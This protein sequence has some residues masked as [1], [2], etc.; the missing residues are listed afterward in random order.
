MSTYYRQFMWL[1][2]NEVVKALKKVLNHTTCNNG[3]QTHP[4]GIPKFEFHSPEPQLVQGELLKF[5]GP[6]ADEPIGYDFQKLKERFPFAIA[7]EL[8][9]DRA[10]DRAKGFNNHRSLK[11]LDFTNPDSEWNRS[12]HERNQA[13]L[14]RI[15]R[16]PKRPFFIN[17]QDDVESNTPDFPEIGRP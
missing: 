10:A 11:N 3:H 13:Y 12:A 14:K 1:S 17:W 5:T 16:R 9:M 8:K 6:R 4:A 15:G 2:K 7:R